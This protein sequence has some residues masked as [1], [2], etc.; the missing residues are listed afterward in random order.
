MGEQEKHRGSPAF[1][2]SCSFFHFFS[3]SLAL[4]SRGR[5]YPAKKH[6]RRYIEPG[7]SSATRSRARF[8]I[9]LFPDAVQ[10][11]RLRRLSSAFSVRLP[12]RRQNAISN[13]F[14]CKL[15]TTAAYKLFDSPSKNTASK[16]QTEDKTRGREGGVYGADGRDRTRK[17]AP[18]KGI[19]ERRRRSPDLL[20]RRA[21]IC[22]GCIPFSLCY[23]RETS[24][25]CLFHPTAERISATYARLPSKYLPFPCPD[26]SWLVVTG[27]HARA[28]LAEPRIVIEFSSSEGKTWHSKSASFTVHFFSL[29]L[30]I[31]LFLFLSLFFSPRGPHI[32]VEF[33]HSTLDVRSEE[34][35]LMNQFILSINDFGSRVRPLA[36]RN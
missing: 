32:V 21:G 25:R 34:A 16:D 36:A 18:E 33:P 5:S 9:W 2:L 19:A 30:S 11:R 35:R 28:R 27:F 24:R 1:F 8:S 29:S 13:Q 31:S 4:L 26:E 22:P 10:Q 20:H 7:K 23:G 6:R 15:K 3:R 12:S 17:G 14:K